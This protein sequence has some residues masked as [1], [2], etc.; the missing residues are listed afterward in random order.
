MAKAMN[1]PSVIIL[2]MVAAI[3]YRRSTRYC[4]T[5]AFANA[6]DAILGMRIDGRRAFDADGLCHFATIVIVV[7]FGFVVANV[8]VL[9]AVGWCREGRGELE[10]AVSLA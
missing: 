8:D 7:R 9:E 2:S 4:Q 5:A 1:G 10:A 6:E 3:L